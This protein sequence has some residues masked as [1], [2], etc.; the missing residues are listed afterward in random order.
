M[1]TLP[2][3]LD[4]TVTIR[5]SCETVFGFFTDSARWAAWWGAG[6][7]I[8]PSPGGLMRIRYPNGVEV[9]GEVIEVLAPERIVF[10]YGYA[11]GSPIAPGASRVTIRLEPHEGGTRLHLTHEFADAAVRDQHVQGWRYQLAVFGNAVADEI[12]RDAAGMVQDWFKSWSLTDDQEREQALAKIAT[13]GV[14]FRD[15]FS[16]TEGLADLSAHIAASR[17]FMPGI[18]LE[19]SGQISQCQGTV[20]APWVERTADGQERMSGTNVFV[21][22]SDGK[23]ESVTGLLKPY[24][25][26][27]E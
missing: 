6:S 16:L 13:A 17:R 2:H 4:R 1:T 12:H 21:L 22:G 14:R 5:A 18:R 11:S 27:S 23:I 26:K 8:E 15:R 19:P 25:R 10:T 9:S 7:S 3:R 24:E 20:L